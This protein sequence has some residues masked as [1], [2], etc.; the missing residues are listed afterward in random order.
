MITCFP[1][2]VSAFLELLVVIIFPIK[3]GENIS[4]SHLVRR[5]DFDWTYG[6]AWGGVIFSIGAAVFFLL[7]VKSEEEVTT[8]YGTEYKETRSDSK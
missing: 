8:F 6:F 5:W 7:P 1:V 3:F 4:Q 2:S